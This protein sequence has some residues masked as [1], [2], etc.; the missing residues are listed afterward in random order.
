MTASFT[1]GKTV[2][3]FVTAF[4]AISVDLG[5]APGSMAGLIAS[6][7]VILTITYE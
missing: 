2:G 6:D 4:L 1:V 5:R 7:K 3:M